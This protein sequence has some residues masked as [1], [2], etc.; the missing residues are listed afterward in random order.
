M[1]KLLKIIYS[2]GKDPV[3]ENKREKQRKNFREK[4]LWKIQKVIRLTTTSQRRRAEPT[5]STAIPSPS[6]AAPSPSTPN[7]HR[8]RRT[9][10][11]IADDSITD[12]PSIFS[13]DSVT[14][15][16]NIFPEDSVT[17]D[18]SV[19]PDDSVTDNPSIIP[20]DSVT[21][22]QSIFP[23]DESIVYPDDELKVYPRRQTK[24]L[25]PTTSLRR[26]PHELSSQKS[27]DELCMA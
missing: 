7:W 3:D 25:F 27:Y 5:P 8:Q 20:D 14:D 22:E 23:D 24:S 11:V 12:D 26:R 15:E 4:S 19:F 17:D 16:L 2:R 1:P 6:N 13:D 21:N 18:P 10:T 9:G